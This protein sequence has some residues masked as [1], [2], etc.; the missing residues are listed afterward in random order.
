MGYTMT[1][2]Y[3]VADN[4]TKIHT[5]W[6]QR[7]RWFLYGLLKSFGILPCAEKSGGAANGG[8]GNNRP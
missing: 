3:Y 5:Y 4:Y 7:G 8:G 6:T 1:R 2:T